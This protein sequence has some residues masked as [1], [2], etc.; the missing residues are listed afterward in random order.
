MASSVFHILNISRQDMLARLTDLDIISNNLANVNTT[1]FKA[2]RANFQELLKDGQL[3]GVHLTSTQTL[4]DQGS[5][6]PTQNALDLAIS[7]EGFFAV[8]MADGR[9]GYT[10]AGEFSQDANGAIITSGGQKLI[11]QGQIPAE[12]EE[13]QVTG[14]GTVLTRTGSTW[15]SAGSIQLTRF[16]N[17]TGLQACGGN[18]WLET[19]SSGVPMAG[20]PGSL[21]F[22]TINSHAIEKSNVNMADE[23]TRL[24][25]LQRAFQITT[26]TF[27][28][29][30]QMIDE[31]IH[32][33]RV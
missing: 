27:Q 12:A 24:V 16:A 1:G 2:S 28:Q 18:L 14:D 29:T 23:M 10:R 33:R 20:A 3:S 32:I 7:G 25:S 31:A 15:T 9:T 5:L 26:R 13:I 8:Q 4:S 21:N 11:W 22:G 30:D 6:I 19:E 17:P